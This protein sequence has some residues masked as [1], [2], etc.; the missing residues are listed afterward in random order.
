MVM[1]VQKVQEMQVQSW[2]GKIPWSRK[3]QPALVLLPGTYH[4]QKSLAGHC[5]WGCKELENSLAAK[6]WLSA[7]TISQQFHFWI[8]IQKC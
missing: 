2:F 5:P 8:Y 7:H 4:G 1:L 6:S 3:W